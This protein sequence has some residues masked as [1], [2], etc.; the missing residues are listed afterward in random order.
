MLVDYLFNHAMVKEQFITEVTTRV[1]SEEL[2]SDMDTNG[3][4]QHLLE[5]V[6]RYSLEVCPGRWYDSFTEDSTV[7]E[8]V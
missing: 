1:S 2:T 4:R 7:Y 3:A 5:V 6:S 8:G